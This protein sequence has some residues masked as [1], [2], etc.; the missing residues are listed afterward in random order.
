[1]KSKKKL[2]F[3]CAHSEKT[4]QGQT[5]KRH[6][7]VKKNKIY[8]VKHQQQNPSKPCKNKATSNTKLAHAEHNAQP[9]Q[10]QRSVT[11]DT[12]LSHV[13]YNALPRPIQRSTA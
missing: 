11:S 2:T 8:I 12:A 5:Q 6:F 1:M 4:Q 13:R 10:T 9:R 3:G 7:F